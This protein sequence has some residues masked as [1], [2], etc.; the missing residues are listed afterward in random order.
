MGVLQEWE[1]NKTMSEKFRKLQKS[2]HNRYLLTNADGEIVISTDS[3]ATYDKER[4]E[5]LMNTHK[6]YKKK[7]NKKTKKASNNDE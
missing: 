1:V 3:K 6:A 5:Y 2:K 7:F 4:L